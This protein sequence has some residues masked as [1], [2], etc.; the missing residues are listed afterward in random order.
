M[1]V[2]LGPEVSSILVFSI[3]SRCART[4]RQKL[5]AIFGYRE[6]VMAV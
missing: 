2:I 5:T 3:I 6:K 4:D 1:D